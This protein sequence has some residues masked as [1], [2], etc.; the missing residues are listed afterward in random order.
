MKKAR[1]G[2]AIAAAVAGVVAF[3]SPA[4]ASI[5]IYDDIMYGGGSRDLGNGL[6]VALGSWND[7][8]SAVKISGTTAK[9]YE[10]ENYGGASTPT[11]SSNK[12][13]LVD[14]HFNDLTSSV[15]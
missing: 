1:L 9:L 7:R 12:S 14:H 3:A 15:Y 5:V 6:Q 11:W 13:N 2:F 10:H 4:Q 8:A